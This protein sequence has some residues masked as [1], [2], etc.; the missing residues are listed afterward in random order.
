ML[1]CLFLA[2]VGNLQLFH[3]GISTFTLLNRYLH[4]HCLKP[5]SPLSL[6]QTGIY[7]FSLSNWHLRAEVYSFKP[8]SQLWRHSPDTAALTPRS[9]DLNIIMLTFT[10]C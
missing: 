4:F 2:D 9:P 7:L 1:L 10:V 6:F 5:A 8:A 3:N